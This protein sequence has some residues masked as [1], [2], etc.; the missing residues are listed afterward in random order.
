MKEL[1]ALKEAD[2]IFIEAIVNMTRMDVL[3]GKYDNWHPK[4]K[5][6]L[7]PILKLPRK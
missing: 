4:A 5:P 1:K 3:E 2:E 7:G 6:P